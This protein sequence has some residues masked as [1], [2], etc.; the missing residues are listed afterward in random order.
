MS[1]VTTYAS[2]RPEDTEE[3]IKE[4][5]AREESAYALAADKLRIDT[6]KKARRKD[7][8][9]P[10]RQLFPILQDKMV[11][12]LEK[13]FENDDPKANN[14]RGNMK[15]LME[16][17][18]SDVICAIFLR[19]MF[20]Q[21]VSNIGSLK[22]ASSSYRHLQ[23]DVC[24]NLQLLCASLK[25]RGTKK[26]KT[27]N[28]MVEYLQ[29]AT[30][31]AACF[32]YVREAADE[33]GIIQ[34]PRR[35]LVANGYEPRGSMDIMPSD[36]FM[37]SIEEVLKDPKTIGRGV[38]LYPMLCK[39]D[40]YYRDNKSPYISDTMKKAWKGQ[41]NLKVV[42]RASH[43]ARILSILNAI[44]SVPVRINKD[45][46]QIQQK[47]LE[48]PL[49]APMVRGK[50]S[51]ILDVPE[52]PHEDA[53]DTTKAL[54]WRKRKYAKAHNRNAK[55]SSLRADLFVKEAERMSGRP[56]Y[57][58]CFPDW[59]GRIYA[60][61]NMSHQSSDRVKALFE[62]YRGCRLGS[63]GL[64]WLK[65]HVATQGDFQ[66]VSKES[67]Q[68][69]ITWVDDNIEKIKEMVNDP[70]RN[71]WWLEADMPFVFYAAC[72]DLVRALSMPYPEA[73]V[74]HIPVAVDGSNSG[75]QHYSAAARAPEGKYVNLV[76][77]S[78]PQDFYQVVAERVIKAAEDTCK[79]YEGDISKLDMDTL[80]AALKEVSRDDQPEEHQ[81]I[82]KDIEALSAHLWLKEGIT[83]SVVKRS[84]MTYVYSSSAYGFTEQVME[85]YMAPL[86][87]A[88]FMEGGEPNP[89]GVLDGGFRAAMWMGRAIY[90]AVK[91]VVPL[92]HK[93]M[94]WL[95]DVA[96]LLASENLP[97]QFMT[98]LGFPV[99]IEYD[100]PEETRIKV[101]TSG[102][103]ISRIR[104][105]K[106]TDVL[107]PKKMASGTPPSTIHAC[108]AA[109]LQ[110]CVE[111]CMD[112]GIQDFL[113]VHDEFM[114]HAGNMQ[115]MRKIILEML[116]RL[117]EKWSPMWAIYDEAGLRLSDAGFQLLQGKPVEGDKRK[118]V[119][120]P[121]LPGELC[122]EGV[123]KA[124]YAFA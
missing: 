66:K 106:R 5:V 20:Q 9:E 37:E 60:A 40:L 114:S 122:L 18:G 75:L 24:R 10:E 92:V 110:L 59:R 84:A 21:S 120:P 108:D 115:R 97:V 2:E 4:Q 19:E 85:D 58:P 23:D 104:V 94:V 51:I 56:L 42:N 33:C 8:T 107:D 6:D 27:K 65:V 74:S 30:N 119:G 46:L 26:I 43:P 71:L 76:P 36:E 99:R 73:Y 31:C 29:E 38:S 112:A 88:S 14:Y 35:D 102:G 77:S 52:E 123:L 11:R 39:P 54:T 78:K 48:V 103:G 28:R 67:F 98:P 101:Q 113:F 61:P 47:M 55:A 72:C 13:N 34:M 117:Y 80:V 90:N 89:F 3:A 121:P 69:R 64:Y 50:E 7:I 15:C 41:K 87:T 96:R 49:L 109:H 25:V 111:G 45:V 124:Q 95:Q 68:T 44:Q 53:L 100:V 70:L 86:N 83:R 81:R 91:D 82:V 93:N 1:D 116:W 16:L 12:Q 22:R 79:E 118:P 17:I 32:Y 57:L 63:N 105:N 62:F